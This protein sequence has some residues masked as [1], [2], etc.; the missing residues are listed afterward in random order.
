MTICHL[1]RHNRTWLSPCIKLIGALLVN[2]LLVLLLLGV[3]MVIDLLD[4]LLLGVRLAV[5]LL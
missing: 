4:V 1:L 5:T 3:R 2:Y